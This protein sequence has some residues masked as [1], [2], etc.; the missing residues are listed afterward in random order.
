[1]NANSWLSAT[2]N[3]ALLQVAVF[4]ALVFVRVCRS[5]MIRSLTLYRWASTLF[6]VSIVLPMVL[7]ILLALFSPE[8]MGVR[9]RSMGVNDMYQY[10]LFTAYSGPIALAISVACFFS[11]LAPP[12][13]HEIANKRSLPE[14][15]PTHPLD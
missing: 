6:I 11:A 14:P 4:L 1:M 10:V 9:S 8:L 2:S 3:L 15:N 13:A 5:Q 12:V 7:T